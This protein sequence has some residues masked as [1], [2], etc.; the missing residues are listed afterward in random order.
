MT[1][2][3]V[4]PKGSENGILNDLYQP[5]LIIP[6]TYNSV[7]LSKLKTCVNEWHTADVKLTPNEGGCLTFHLT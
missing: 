5:Q 2:A 1:S 7:N 6:T 3:N 4:F